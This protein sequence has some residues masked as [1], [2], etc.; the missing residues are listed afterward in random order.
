MDSS[1]G[2]NPDEDAYVEEYGYDDNGTM[3]ANVTRFAHAII[4]HK[5]VSAAKE[6]REDRYGF[7]CVFVVTLDSGRQV[8]LADTEDCCAY[9]ALESFLLNSK[10]IDHVITRVV[11]DH[12]FSTWRVL[13]DYADVLKMQVGWSCGNP[14]YYTYGFDIKVIDPL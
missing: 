10:H 9:T 3:S 2:K 6:S 14:F 4:G 11:T 5:I 12:H 1:I 8:I 13:A 7:Q